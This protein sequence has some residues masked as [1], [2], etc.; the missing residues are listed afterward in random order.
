MS[1]IK[2]LFSL[3]I[4][5]LYFIQHI[6][7]QII[8]SSYQVTNINVSVIPFIRRQLLIRFQWNTWYQT[9]AN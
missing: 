9:M 3:N 8:N 6:F 2:L 4:R 5:Q 7:M 1:T